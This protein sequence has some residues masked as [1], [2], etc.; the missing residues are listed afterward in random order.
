MSRKHD[1]T[2]RGNRLV[3]RISPEVCSRCPAAR[4]SERDRS[5]LSF[6]EGYLDGAY[7]LR[8]GRRGKGGPVWLSAMPMAK[9]VSMRLAF[10]HANAGDFCFRMGFDTAP[11]FLELVDPFAA[12]GAGRER[13]ARE[14]VNGGEF[15]VGGEQLGRLVAQAAR[16]SVNRDIMALCPCY[17]E[18]FIAQF[19]RT[20]LKKKTEEENP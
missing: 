4:L 14:A 18:Q 5:R 17:A 7:Y 19:S 9:A 12:E 1:T 13:P 15:A 6:R 11:E 8:A 20:A 16:I 3:S 2:V 10:R